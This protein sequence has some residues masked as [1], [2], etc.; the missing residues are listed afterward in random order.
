[1]VCVR[2]CVGVCARVSVCACVCACLCLCLCNVIHF[3]TAITPCIPNPCLN[4]G[5][6]RPLRSLPTCFCPE[7]YGNLFCKDGKSLIG[8]HESTIHTGV[9]YLHDAM[10]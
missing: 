1:M 8:K 2:T 6:C 3:C 7:H 4:G 10:A 5:S 9:S